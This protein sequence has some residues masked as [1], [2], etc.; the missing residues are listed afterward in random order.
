MLDAKMQLEKALLTTYY[1]NLLFLNKYDKK[2]F[3]RVDHLSKLIDEGKYEER[4]TL[5]FIQEIGD[6]DIYDT[7]NKKYLYKKKPKEFIKKALS[8]VNA[9]TKGSFTILEKVLYKNDN[10]E[11]EYS[12]DVDQFDS[13]S[14]YL[15]KDISFYRNIL[16][17]DLFSYSEQKFKEI[18]KFMFIGTL[19]GRHI[20]EITK[21]LKPKN[22]FICEY[23]IEIFRLSL[24]VFD[25]T[26]LVENGNTAVFS[27]M[28]DELEFKSNLEIFLK[29]KPYYNYNIKYYTTDYDVKGYFDPIL[30]GLIGQ[31]STAFNHHMMLKSVAK[32]A[33]SRSKGYN[34]VQ[35]KD[36]QKKH[37]IF[38]EK[39]VLYVGAGPSL[40]SNIE[41]IRTNKNKFIIVAMG[42]SYKKLLEY[43]IIPDIV[44]TLDPEFK[45]LDEFHF[46][47]ESLEKIPNSIIFAST[48]TND[49]IL[50]KFNPENLYLYEIINPLHSTNLVTHGYSIGE[51]IGSML[52]LLG[53]KDLY[54]VG[55]DLALNQDTG[56]THMSGYDTGSKYKI[57]K[58]ITHSMDKGN[59][60]LRNDLIEVKGNSRDKV[61]T[62]RLF[63]TSLS[64]F[65][66]SLNR[67][68]LKNQNV[69]NISKDGAYIDKTKFIASENINLNSFLDIDRVELKIKLNNYLKKISKN[70]LDNKDKDIL[71][72]EDEYLKNIKEELLQNKRIITTF[73]DFLE[74]N[75]PII[76]NLYEPKEITSFSR[77][78][79][80]FFFNSILPYVFYH[81]NQKKLKKEKTKIK[82]VEKIFH[83][84]IID[85]IDLYRKYIKEAL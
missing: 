79:F 5:E 69:Y 66:H 27:I 46:D 75:E 22:F 39:P 81:F 52:V 70:N 68:L 54:L 10:S 45:I 20:I 61:L 43:D 25:Y 63:S 38:K 73:K 80:T 77:P 35:L 51:I 13:A 12:E 72:K 58:V 24:F 56:E 30:D 32:N 62:T 36:I 71:R 82:Q 16:D 9:D 11:F 64:S 65:S 76:S 4:F 47:D 50:K 29:H 44:S 7:K 14:K 40:V 84:Q 26:L 34:I 17:D 33:L 8:S 83:K 55:I 60:S 53:V 3:E 18:N 31:K 23:N 85:I 6:F 15:L 41:W 67:L 78:I 28:D 42:A 48:N 74:K 57:D 49:R 19:L 1:A 2:L 21:K 37:S 59:F